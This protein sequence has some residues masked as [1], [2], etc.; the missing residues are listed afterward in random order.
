MSAERNSLGIP[1]VH[2]DPSMM[3][4]E[5]ALELAGMARTGAEAGMAIPPGCTFTLQG[6]TGTVPDLGPRIDRY[7]EAIGRASLAMFLNLGHDTGA[8]AMAET[9]LTF[10]TRSLQ[11]VAT[12][13]GDTFS[14]HVI[15]DLVEW[16]FGP[17][18][19]YPRLT[20]GDLTTEMA[21][22]PASF[23]ALVSAKVITPDDI[24]EQAVRRRY[25]LPDADTKTARKDPVQPAVPPGA[26]AVPVVPKKPPAA[27]PVPSPRGTPSE[28]KP[29]T[30]AGRVNPYK[31]AVL[32]G[33]ADPAT[34]GAGYAAWMQSQVPV[35]AT[36]SGYAAWLQAQVDTLAAE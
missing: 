29:F 23:Q 6:V 8:R 10:F 21:L 35:T 7:N 28:A 18:E 1:V 12:R 34:P 20:P 4:Y 17:D 15:R 19:P 30:D 26:V 2:Y 36:L 5:S 27:A 3:T 11:G 13:L 9:F 32:A 25:R 14:E 24:L 22:P 16:N 31:P 33:A